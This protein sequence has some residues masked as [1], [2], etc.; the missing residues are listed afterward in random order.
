MYEWI[1]VCVIWSPARRSIPRAAAGTSRRHHTGCQGQAKSTARRWDSISFLHHFHKRRDVP[2]VFTEIRLAFSLRYAFLII[3]VHGD[4]VRDMKFVKWLLLRK[5]RF[6][7]RTESHGKYFL[8][9]L[10]NLCAAMSLWQTVRAPSWVFCAF[11][12][13]TMAEKTVHEQHCICLW[14]DTGVAAFIQSVDAN[15]MERIYACLHAHIH[16]I[17]YNHSNTLI[18]A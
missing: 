13:W 4:V 6:S 18:F 12:M 1:F 10:H 17:M 3:V 8:E 2:A 15:S 14:H 11:Y 5:K 16:K 9:N 7:P